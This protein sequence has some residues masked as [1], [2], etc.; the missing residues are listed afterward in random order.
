[1]FNQMDLNPDDI[2]QVRKNRQMVKIN[3]KSS[4]FPLSMGVRSDLY[5][6]S[7]AL[8]YTNELLWGDRPS[9]LLN[10][11]FD[12]NDMQA[13]I[14]LINENESPFLDILRD[15]YVNNSRSQ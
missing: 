4:L 7:A 8:A 5:N 11:H 1:M 13:L 12:Q 14:E 10:P 6:S 3:G 9:R 15:A 2:R